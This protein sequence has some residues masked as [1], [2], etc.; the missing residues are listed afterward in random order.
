MNRYQTVDDMLIYATCFHRDLGEY[1]RHRGENPANP[2]LQMI[3][4]YM[5]DHEHKL[6][7][8]LQRYR[9]SADPKILETWLDHVPEM[10][11]LPVL[12]D[13]TDTSAA[14]LEEKFSGAAE[15]D[16]IDI[17]LAIDNRLIEAYEELARSATIETVRDL[18]EDLAEQQRSEQR[19]L[20]M[21]SVRMQDI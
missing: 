15:D 1:Y 4:N 8:A 9:D 20:Q 19:R 17:A 12:E 10:D 11:A 2:R 3:M 7:T 5:A 13:I 6:A 16:V 18:F 14:D 21:S